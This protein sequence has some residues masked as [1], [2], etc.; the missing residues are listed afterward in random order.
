MPPLDSSQSEGSVTPPLSVFTPPQTMTPSGS[1]TPPLHSSQSE[2][3]VTP[4]LSVSTPQQTMMPSVS[5]APTR[6]LSV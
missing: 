5:Y 4:P 3:S 2:G 1:A 6:Q